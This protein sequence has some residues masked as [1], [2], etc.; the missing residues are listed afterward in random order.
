MHTMKKALFAATAALCALLFLAACG[1]NAQTPAA[2]PTETIETTPAA[3]TETTQ[4]MTT[5]TTTAQATQATASKTTQ[6][7]AARTTTKAAAIK[8]AQAPTPPQRSDL[9]RLTVYQGH[10]TL[11]R[12]LPP[13]RAIQGTTSWTFEDGAVVASDSPHPLQRSLS[14]YDEATVNDLILHLDFSDP[15][16]TI[17]VR[18]WPTAYLLLPQGETPFER[19]KVVPFVYADDG[20]AR[21][22]R[23]SVDCIY[24]VE[25]KWP[26]GTIRYSFRAAP[27]N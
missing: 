23:D 13:V 16:Q 8:A 20:R 25:A 15:P 19:Y 17:Q 6:T 2:A 22:E 26:S 11:S 14:A 12:V 3:I 7:T 27:A 21:F 24:E 9:P 1:G 10:P 5:E 18:Q 4:T